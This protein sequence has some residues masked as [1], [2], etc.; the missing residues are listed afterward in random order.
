M[1]L[2]ADEQLNLAVAVVARE[3]NSVI[4][5]RPNR[6]E[7][8]KAAH[9]RFSHG[10]TTCPS[11]CSPSSALGNVAPGNGRIDVST[12]VDM[13]QGLPLGANRMLLDLTARAPG[14]AQ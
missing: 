9:G 11:R 2:H 5:R 4:W 3:L 6:T 13:Y 10:T 7:N 12:G 14:P 1:D 8:A